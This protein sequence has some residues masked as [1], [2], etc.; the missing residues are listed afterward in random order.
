MGDISTW[1]LTQIAL[2]FLAWC[3]VIVA[4]TLIAW[5]LWSIS[6]WFRDGGC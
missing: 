1:T 2:A 6:E 4:A 5:V 3:G